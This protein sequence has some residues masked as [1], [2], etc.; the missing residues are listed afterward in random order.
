MSTIKKLP[1]GSFQLTVRHRLLPKAF[2]STFSSLEEAKE[3]G[4]RLDGLLKQGFVPSPLLEKKAAEGSWLLSRCVAE[5]VKA[6]GVPTS[7][8][9]I[10]D[11]LRPFLVSESTAGMNYEWCANW[12]LRLKRVENLA[13]ST[14]RHRVGALKRCLDWVVRAHPEIL[15]MNPLRQLKAGFST[16]T[17]DD[18]QALIRNG[19]AKKFDTRR[20]RRLHEG[21]EERILEALQNSPDEKTFFVI[22]LETAMR[23]REIYTLD[24]SQVSL[25]KAT[26]HL[27]ETKNGDNRQ[28][29]LPT[30]A[31]AEFTQYLQK[32]AAAI[33]ARN[34]RV[35]PFWDGK[36]ADAD[37]DKTTAE[38]SRIFRK[39]FA[40]A[41][42][43]DFVFHDIRHEATCRLFEKSDLSD[44][45]ISRVT[46]HRD[47]RMLQRYAS[48]RGSDVAK[49]LW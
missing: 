41:K 34:G 48:F 14:I 3:Y 22:A 32:N 39:V 25:P 10:L 26:V 4:D 30:P 36:P 31:I 44:I 45:E 6:G 40:A 7:E 17:D 11:T 38:V 19:K 2:Y 21:E 47:P 27:V 16:Y 35:F 8:I 13:P 33:K 24:L 9:K 28:V 42:I 12:V 49:K 18:E 46:G 37:L 23:M 20:D 43:P 29:P 5:Y 1:S 15:V